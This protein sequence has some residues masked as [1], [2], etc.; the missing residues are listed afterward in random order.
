MVLWGKAFG[1]QL[2]FSGVVRVEPSWMGFLPL[3]EW[4]ESLL[5][6]PAPTTEDAVRSWQSVAQKTT[7]IVSSLGWHPDLG[8]PASTTIGHKSLLLISYPVYG[9]SV[10]AT[11]AEINIEWRNEYSANRLDRKGLLSLEKASLQG[12]PL[13]GIWECG[14]GRVPTIPRIDKSRLNY[15]YKHFGL[16]W[17]PAFS[18]GVWNIGTW[19]AEGTYAI[20]LQEK[21][22]T[23]SPLSF[24]G[25]AAFHMCGHSSSLGA[26]S[27][28]HVTPP[29]GN[30]RKSMPGLSQTLTHHGVPLLF[31]SVMP[32]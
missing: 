22:G 10:I 15:L 17:T 25:V 27:I 24:P 30:F 4:Q 12:R 20:C 7:L 1:K 16:H 9:T 31:C 32:Y 18:L 11:W 21:L 14:F 28:F 2:G 5:P 29:G 8:L 26:L 6:L 19:Q 23:E 3:S 13:V